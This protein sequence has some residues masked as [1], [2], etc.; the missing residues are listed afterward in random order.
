MSLVLRHLAVLSYA[1]ITQLPIIL[2]AH[3]AHGSD[4][5]SCIAAATADAQDFTTDAQPARNSKRLKTSKRTEKV[6]RF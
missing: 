6:V 2:T 4:S 5:V 3:A 1:V